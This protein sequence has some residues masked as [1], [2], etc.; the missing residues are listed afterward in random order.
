MGATHVPL[1]L[2]ILASDQPHED[3][4]IPVPC[5]ECFRVIERA[6]FEALDANGERTQ[7][8]EFIRRRIYEVL[9]GEG[10]DPGRG[11]KDVSA[12]GMLHVAKLREA[13]ARRKM[14]AVCICGTN[15]VPEPLT[16]CLRH[17]ERS[18]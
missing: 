15:H 8:S 13:K 9:L 4:V 5:D 16:R 14:K 7:I 3:G 17:P 10:V 11:V 6:M 2:Q 18:E 1:N 12:T